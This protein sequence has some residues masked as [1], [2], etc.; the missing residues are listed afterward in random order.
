MQWI[1][2]RDRAYWDACDSVANDYGYGQSG[3]DD[4]SSARRAM[5]SKTARIGTIS[6]LSDL[7]WRGV[8]RGPD[9]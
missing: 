9:W 6:R 2:G 1:R 5:D 4:V 7:S 3:V 8:Q